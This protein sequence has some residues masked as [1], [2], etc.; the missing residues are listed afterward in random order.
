MK[1]MLAIHMASWGWKSK[2]EAATLKCPKFTF[3]L[4]PALKDA[5]SQLCHMNI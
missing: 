4:N 1:M 2:G 3:A 5:A